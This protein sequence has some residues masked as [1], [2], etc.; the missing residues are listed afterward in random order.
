MRT[1]ITFLVISIAPSLGLAAPTLTEYRYFTS[2]KEVLRANHTTP[3]TFNGI[4]IGTIEHNSTTEPGT[5]HSL[6][7]GH[8]FGHRGWY[9]TDTNGGAWE[10]LP[11]QND[12]INA[13]PYEKRSLEFIGL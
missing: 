8:H 1:A 12:Q 11:K 5:I 9:I 4:P 7:E 2:G 6:S 13:S 10:Y 3:V